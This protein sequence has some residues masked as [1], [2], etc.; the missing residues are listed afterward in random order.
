MKSC[1]FFLYFLYQNYV[2]L[3]GGYFPKLSAAQ[4]GLVSGGLSLELHSVAGEAIA[5]L[6]P[7]PSQGQEASSGRL[8]DALF[9]LFSNNH[10]MKL[11]LP[12]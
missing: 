8:G 1:K 4:V 10:S 6:V 11:H 7:L 2:F 12:F 9:L 5:D 3:L